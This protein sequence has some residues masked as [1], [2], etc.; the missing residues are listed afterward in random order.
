MADERGWG[1]IA[2]GVGKVVEAFAQLSHS[3]IALYFSSEIERQLEALLINELPKLNKRSRE[4]LFGSGH[5]PLGSLSSK[6]HLAAAMGL[7]DAQTT[8]KL[9]AIR[10]VRNAFAHCD[11]GVHFDH[12][13]IDEKI[14]KLRPDPN[15]N[16]LTTYTDAANQVLQQLH[17]KLLFVALDAR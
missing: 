7:L 12:P 9:H 14:K 17:N 11:P 3:A 15:Q 6:I 1:E 8:E 10:D 4:G 2:E 13:K 16:N 5:A